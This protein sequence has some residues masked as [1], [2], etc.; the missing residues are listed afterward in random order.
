MSG[1]R[2]TSSALQCRYGIWHSESCTL[3]ANTKPIQWRCTPRSKKYL[4]VSPTLALPSA[5]KVIS[6]HNNMADV[7]VQPDCVEWLKAWCGT[8]ESNVHPLT[9]SENC[10]R[11]RA[12]C[13]MQNTSYVYTDQQLRAEQW[14]MI[15]VRADVQS[16]GSGQHKVV[17]SIVDAVE[18]A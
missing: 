14:A 1:S 10:V 15:R 7:L 8:V 9:C 11:M 3:G 16:I 18:V 13:A 4:A 5:V 17:V 12:E 2:T 6:V